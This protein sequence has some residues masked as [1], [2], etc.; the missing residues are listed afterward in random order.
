MP[1]KLRRWTV[2]I[3]LFGAADSG[4]FWAG[5]DEIRNPGR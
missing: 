1:K 3:V 5:G 2:L 4:F